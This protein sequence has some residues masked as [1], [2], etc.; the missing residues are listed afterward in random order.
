MEGRRLTTEVEAK[1]AGD[2][3]YFATLYLGSE[4]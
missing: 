3:Y 2:K 1:N 4:K